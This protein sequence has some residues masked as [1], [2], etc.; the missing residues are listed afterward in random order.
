MSTH[1]EHLAAVRVLLATTR[2]TVLTYGETDLIPEAD[3]PTDYIIVDLARM[4]GGAEALD[5]TV[6]STM[7]RLGTLAVSTD[8]DNANV[9]LDDC[10]TALEGKTMPV[11]D[12]ETGPVCFE[13][14]VAV[15]ADDGMFSGRTDWTYDY[16]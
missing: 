16:S 2:R 12:T 6:A 5:G 7:W 14:A 1:A 10:A 11:G 8:E 13:S 4:F 15:G 9:L 3:R